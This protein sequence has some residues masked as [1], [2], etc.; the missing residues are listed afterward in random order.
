MGEFPSQDDNTLIGAELVD[1]RHAALG[2]ARP[3]G[4]PR[5]R[6]VDVARFGS[7]A[8]TLVKRRGLVVTEMPRAWHQFDTMQLAGAI[9]AEFD[10]AGAS[11]PALI[12]A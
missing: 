6:G 3:H 9:K 1:E 12:I 7:D 8:S 11:R 10:A 2:R 5:S 4:D